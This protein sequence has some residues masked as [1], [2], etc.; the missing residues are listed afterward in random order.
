MRWIFV[1]S[2]PV[3]PGRLPDELGNGLAR[4]PIHPNN[5]QTML[6]QEFGQ[7]LQGQ[8]LDRCTAFACRMCGMRRCL[9]LCMCCWLG[10]C[11]ALLF[12]I[13]AR[14]WC[15]LKPRHGRA[16]KTKLPATPSGE[17]MFAIF[18]RWQPSSASSVPEGNDTQGH[19]VSP[20]VWQ[21][22][23]FGFRP[24]TLRP[25]LSPGLPLSG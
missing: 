18:L 19:I 6:A 17:C 4:R 5:A 7:I 1:Q 25:R 24:M 21:S 20:A 2:G 22:W 16:G 3:W 10:Y 23:P 13:L 14:L 15:S 12:H 11:H 8:D 9:R